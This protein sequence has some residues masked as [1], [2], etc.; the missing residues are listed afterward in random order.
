MK[1]SLLSKDVVEFAEL[2]G[3]I[4]FTTLLGDSVD[5]TDD[6]VIKMSADEDLNLLAYEELD[7]LPDELHLLFCEFQMLTQSMDPLSSHRQEPLEEE[8]R[9]VVSYCVGESELSDLY[10]S[11]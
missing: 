8:L 11:C 10:R 7:D 9:Y 3:V 6:E 2:E 1:L 4:T 5:S